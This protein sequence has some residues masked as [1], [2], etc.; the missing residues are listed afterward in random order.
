MPWVHLH[1]SEKGTVKACCIAQ[2]PFGNVNQSSFD[3]I[4]NGD[5]IKMLR[6]NFL[7]GQPDKRCNV[8]IKQELAGAKSIRQESWEKYEALSEFNTEVNEKPSYFDIR[9]SNIC[10]FRCRTCWHAASSKWYNEAVSLKRTKSNQA[11][12]ENIDDFEAFIDE[13]GSA[14]KGAKEIYFAGG[15][16]LITE[17]HYKLL[18]WLIH[19]KV[20]SCKLRYNTNFSHLKFKT[21]DVIALWRHFSTVEILASLDGY[22]QLGEYIRKE[23][24]WQ[25]I[26]INRELLRSE[27]QIKFQISP[28][29]ST[30]SIFHLPDFYKEALR[31]N[32]IEADGVYF[33]ILEYPFYYNVKAFPKSQK[34]HIYKHY[35]DFFEWAKVNNI[36]KNVTNGFQSCLEYMFNE[37]LSSHWKA[38]L[39]ET[40]LIDHLREEKLPQQWVSDLKLI[41]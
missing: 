25:Q 41:E 32:L 13:F 23:M 9:F 18:E 16:P 28:T 31:L 21:Y 11:I 14:L 39:K 8:C 33:N 12:I 30:L 20:T 36:P 22:G 6:T 26:L 35:Q 3:E 15:E 5:P 2:I 4:W 10:N 38:F 37:D 7:T 34:E 19:H 1:V 27:S 40:T 29:V 24:D 17:F